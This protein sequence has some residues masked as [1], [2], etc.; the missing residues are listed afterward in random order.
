MIEFKVPDKVHSYIINMVQKQDWYCDMD[1]AIISARMKTMADEFFIKGIMLS[2]A[3]GFAGILVSY[4]FYI[5]QT[6]LTTVPVI[7]TVYAVMILIP[8]I[9]FYMSLTFIISY[10]KVQAT[11]RG[12]IIDEKM[13]AFA[14]HMA[15]LLQNNSNLLD[16]FELID[17]SKLYGEIGEEIEI[18]LRRTA[19]NINFIDAIQEVAR[20]TSSYEFR[21]YLNGIVE[22]TL[23]VGTLDIHLKNTSENLNRLL[24]TKTKEHAHDRA[25]LIEIYTVSVVMMPLMILLAL[26]TTALMGDE[27]QVGDAVVYGYIPFASVVFILMAERE[28]KMEV[29]PER[30]AAEETGKGKNKL[31]EKFNIMDY[32]NTEDGRLAAGAIA[33]LPVAYLAMRSGFGIDTTIMIFFIVAILPYGLY[34]RGEVNR[35]HKEEEAMPIFLRNV[36]DRNRMGYGMTEIFEPSPVYEHINKKVKKIYWLLKM[37]ENL[38]TAISMLKENGSYI[39]TRGAGIIND[40]LRCGGNISKILES[41]GEDIQN[42]I[43]INREIEGDMKMNTKMIMATYFLFVGITWLINSMFF[44]A[45]S[46]P[47]A[48]VPLD[49]A[50]YRRLFYHSCALTGIFAG[51]V[52]SRYEQ[53]DLRPGFVFS[54]FFTFITVVVFLYV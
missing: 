14:S 26:M 15:I 36:A 54:S 53:G 24:S 46:T 52:I 10:P 4:L 7:L 51:L 44:K 43:N 6:G 42:I 23:N 18:I 38:E 50:Y 16:A 3:I 8:V 13:P 49:M 34:W 12:K 28:I 22:T 1:R 25:A 45:F 9:C 27:M 21:K 32:L 40:A 11:E 5:F 30:T 33:G 2:V 47:G 39:M 17:K 20:T 29:R 48:S 19:F 41:V 35:L 37:G 31:K